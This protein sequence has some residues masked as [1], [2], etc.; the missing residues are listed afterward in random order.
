MLS[1]SAAVCLGYEI[2]FAVWE[3]RNMAMLL[4]LL[5]LSAT[6]LLPAAVTVPVPLLPVATRRD[7]AISSCAMT[8]CLG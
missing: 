3:R 4:L 7:P 8:H 6:Y 5:L 2:I 1:D